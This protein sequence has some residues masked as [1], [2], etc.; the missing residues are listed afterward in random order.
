ML[1]ICAVMIAS[2]ALL[3]Y[4]TALDLK[5]ESLS[6][7]KDIAYTKH[8]ILGDLFGQKDKGNK[9]SRFSTYTLE[10]D[11]RNNTCY[12]DGFGEVENMTEDN[13]K[14]INDLIKAVHSHNKNEG[15]IEEYNMRFYV[16][17][18]PF[19]ERIVLLDKSYEDDQLAHLL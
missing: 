7:I 10:I 8:D 6:A 19:G 16:A 12:I 13:I 11:N 2:F 1:L 4:N 18:T 14:Y 3:Y 5:N 17:T 15:Y 9:Y